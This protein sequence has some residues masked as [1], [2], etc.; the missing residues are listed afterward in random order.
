MAAMC[1][2]QVQ[3]FILVKINIVGVK[4]TLSIGDRLAL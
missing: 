4:G 1:F 3:R 2:K